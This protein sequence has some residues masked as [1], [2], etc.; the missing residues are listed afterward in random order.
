MLSQHGTIHGERKKDIRKGRRGRLKKDEGK[1]W[2]QHNRLPVVVV[3]Q[4]VPGSRQPPTPVE[5]VA[6]FESCVLN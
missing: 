6:A 5:V 4:P 1:E 2:H 3:V